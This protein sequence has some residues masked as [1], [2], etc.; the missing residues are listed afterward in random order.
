L[1]ENI[2]QDT[3]KHQK[4]HVST[5]PLSHYSILNFPALKYHRFHS[6]KGFYI[7]FTSRQSNLIKGMKKKQQKRPKVKITQKKREDFEMIPDLP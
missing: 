7:K 1:G 4:N 3:I 2:G 5:I 6:I